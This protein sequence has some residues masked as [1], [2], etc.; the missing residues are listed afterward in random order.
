MNAH[1]LLRRTGFLAWGW[2]I[3]LAAAMATAPARAQEAPPQE[4]PPQ[5]APRIIRGTTVTHQPGVSR[6]FGA[7]AGFSY[8]AGFATPVVPNTTQMVGGALPLGGGYGPYQPYGPMLYGTS[9]PGYGYGFGTGYGFGYLGYGYGYPGYTFGFGN[10]SGS[11]PNAGM[12]YYGMPRVYVPAR[13]GYY[14]R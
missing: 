3:V 9:Y 12:P 2:A 7:T 14:R 1:M 8:Q 6:S 11:I 10:V 5:E 13:G 4:A